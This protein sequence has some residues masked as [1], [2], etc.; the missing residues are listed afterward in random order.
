[1]EAED[2]HR[3]RDDQ[4]IPGDERHEVADSHDEHRSGHELPLAAD[5]A[6]PSDEEAGER[7]GHSLQREELS[8][9]RRVAAEPKKDE[10]RQADVEEAAAD[11]RRGDRD[12]EAAERRM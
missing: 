9:A 3:D 4:E 10:H 6:V 1:R 8:D 5:R 7:R 12:P 2:E 11:V